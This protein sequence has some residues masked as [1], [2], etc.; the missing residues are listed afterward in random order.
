[1]TGFGIVTIARCQDLFGIV[2]SVWSPRELQ[3][4][5]NSVSDHRPSRFI[6]TQRALDDGVV[7]EGCELDS[8]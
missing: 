6:C 1:M 7:F 8:E 5:P 4:S 3:G 2:Y